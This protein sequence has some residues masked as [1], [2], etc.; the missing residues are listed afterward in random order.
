[1]D[2]VSSNTP[3]SLITDKSVLEIPGDTCPVV[4]PFSKA[5]KDSVTI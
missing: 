5:R 3:V 2:C 1:M 4:V